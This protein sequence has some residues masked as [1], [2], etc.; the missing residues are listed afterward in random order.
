MSSMRKAS[1][2]PE[3]G[4][5]DPRQDANHAMGS[6]SV[7]CRF[8]LERPEQEEWHA[9]WQRAVHSHAE[10]H[11]LFAEVERARDRIPVYV[12]AR[13]AGRLVCTGLLSIRPWC[14]GQ[15]LSLEAVCMHGP[16]CDD[17]AHLEQTMRVMIRW[18]RV[19]RVGRLRISPYWAYPE[20]EALV[21]MLRQNGFIPYYPREG[22]WVDTG[23]VDL[24][25]SSEQ[26]LASFSKWTRK[27]IRRVEKLG[28]EIRA[29]TREEEAFVA[30]RSLCRLRRERGLTPMSS[31]EFRGVFEHVL[32]DQDVGALFSAY[33]GDRFLGALWLA[34][35]PSVAKTEG[36][37]VEARACAALSNSLSIGPPL[38]WR[39]IEWAKQRGCAWLDVWG[40]SETTPPES[41]V[42]E[43]HQFK[44]KFRPLPTR[45]LNEHIC[46]CNRTLHAVWRTQHFFQRVRKFTLSLPYQVRT[47]GWFRC[48]RATHVA[49]DPEV[50]EPSSQTGTSL[51]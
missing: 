11:L 44:K 13:V 17:L 45:V 24:R 42:Y 7:E 4:Y 5:P 28:I 43:I 41:P 38:W 1:G 36:Y 16:V 20:A 2:G 8:V 32:R 39:G 15:R 35:G 33:A 49:S 12:S 51:R 23:L 3:G 31:G 30:F 18:C 22:N 9:F 29:V 46:V 50:A 40:Y 19:H 37:V 47:R 48:S 10:Q 26:L 6:P 34:R 27:D 25:C 21:S 14:A